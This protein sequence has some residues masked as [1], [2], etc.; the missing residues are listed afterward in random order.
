MTYEAETGA[1]SMMFSGDTLIS[2]ALTPF[3]EKAFLDLRSLLRSADVRFSNG[4]ILFHDY[5]DQPGYPSGMSVRCD[6]KFIQD[7]Q[8]LGI[9]LLS[10]AN[11]HAYDF[12][13]GGV[14]TNIRN[15]DAANLAHSGTGRN[16]AEAVAPAYL[17]TAAGRVALISATT[18]GS[19]YSRAGEQRSDIQGRSG[20]NL[21]RWTNRW[22][23]DAETFGALQRMSDHFRWPQRVWPWWQAAYGADEQ[24]QTLVR[25]A[26]RNTLEVQGIFSDDPYATFVLGRE[27]AHTTSIHSLDLAR[28]VA[29]V[30]RACAMADWVIFSVHN[31][32]GGATLD[33]PAEH[34]VE[35]AHAVIEAGAHV[36]VGHGPHR[37]RGIEIYENRPI[38]Y[39]LSSL[40]DEWE[41]MTP[42]PQEVMLRFGLKDEDSVAELLETFYAGQIADAASRTSAV[43]HVSFGQQQ[44]TSL[45][46]HPIDLGVPFPRSQAG[47]PLLADG[48]AAEQV[49][50]RFEHL[51]AALHTTIERR[52]RTGVVKLAD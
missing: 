12:G 7:L 29:S 13:A 51:S 30:K 4:E 1:I 9:N 19:S 46:I 5:E 6:P 2:R 25:L 32:E 40:V 26:D 35:L 20:T 41:T 22:T 14:L 33:D 27:F 36:V 10:C 18:T 31:H 50:D 49:L 34:V 43:V 24:S 39:S 47:R 42:M 48:A 45:T 21:I 52:G 16:Y 38:L 44:L 28:N 8:W 3:R 37:D 17:D 15:L 11:N 23:V